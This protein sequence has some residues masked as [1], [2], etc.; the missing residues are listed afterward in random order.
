MISLAPRRGMN[1]FV[2]GDVVIDAGT[3]R[4]ARRVVRSLGDHPVRALALTHVHPDHHGGSW[5]VTR[6]LGIELWAPAA[7]ADAAAA[8][9]TRGMA[10]KSLILELQQ[11]FWQGPG[12]IP[13]REVR[14]GDAI[15]SGFVAIETPGH[16]PGHLCFWRARDRVLIAGDVM[17]NMSPLTGRPGLR[18]PP[19]VFT[20]DVEANRRS[21]DRLAGLEPEVVCFGHGPVLRGAAVP[22]REFAARC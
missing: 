18:E 14:E 19:T 4:G 5:R 21:I 3:H 13:A 2:A 16:S 17:W 8:G 20:L 6:S 10:P 22:M 9:E 1:V 7:E 11:R 15:G 12:V